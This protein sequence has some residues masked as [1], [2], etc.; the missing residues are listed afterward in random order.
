MINIRYKLK[1][2]NICK[3]ISIINNRKLFK[4]LIFTLFLFLF[5]FIIINVNRIKN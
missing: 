5:L 4:L 3:F 2:L 1:I